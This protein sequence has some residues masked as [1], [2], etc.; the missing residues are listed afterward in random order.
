VAI[1][2]GF[3]FPEELYYLV[4][5]HVWT[6]SLG[7][8]LVQVGLTPVAYKLLRNSLVAI[9]IRS[10]QVGREVSQGRSIAM[11]ES[12]KYIGP[13]AAPFTGRLVR[14]NPQVQADPDLAAADPYG[15]G[16]IAEM[17]PADWETARAGLV[18][19]P[20]AMVAYQALLERQNVTF[21]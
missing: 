5:K 15:E 18:T 16:W 21:D 1:I 8:G 11:V 6:R 3:L 9:S 10:G 7:G 20:A 14:G 2:R 17:E 4:E 19:G 13:L 12:V